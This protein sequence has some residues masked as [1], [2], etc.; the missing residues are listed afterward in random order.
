MF[1]I[2]YKNKV[3]ST[4][5]EKLLDLTNLPKNGPIVIF[6]TN[7]AHTES[8]GSEHSWIR[9]HKVMNSMV[10]TSSDIDLLK[11]VVIHLL[12][13]NVKIECINNFLFQGRF[14]LMFERFAHPAIVADITIG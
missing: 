5:D 12:V 11:C 13:F 7:R 14:K 10:C 6:V 4:I 3:L 8:I 1:G 2:R 9:L